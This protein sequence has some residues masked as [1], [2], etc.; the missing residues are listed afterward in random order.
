MDLCFVH[1]NE[2]TQK[3]I[4]IM[5]K[6]LQTLFWNHHT[7]AL[8]VTMSK[9]GTHLAD[10]FFIPN[11]SCKIGTPVSCDMPMASI[12]SLTFTLRSVKTISWTLSMMS[13]VAIS[14]ERPERGASHVE[15]HSPN[16]IQLQTLVQ[17]LWTSNSALIS[18]GVKPFICRS[19]VWLL[20]KTHFFPFCKKYKDCSL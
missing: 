19:Y 3:F 2:S 6:H 18:V 15:I 17:M 8:I 5:L 10:S 20:H 7:I 9:R 4:W 12:S 16:C 13:D 14:I 11:C 1:N